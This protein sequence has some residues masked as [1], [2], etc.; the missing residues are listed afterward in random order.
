MF[1]QA[2]KHGRETF[3]VGAEN[4]SSLYFPV[5]Q[6]L[7]RGQTLAVAQ[8][9]KAGDTSVE[10]A[11]LVFDG[12]ID[13]ANVTSRPFLK[14]MRAIVPSMRHLAPQAPAV[15]LVFAT[16][17]L[18]LTGSPGAHATRRRKPGTPNAGEVILALKSL[19][20]A[21]DFSNGSDRAGGFVSPNLSV[22]AMSR[23]LGRRRRSVSA[24]RRQVRP[25]LVPGGGLPEA[26]RTLQPAGSP[27]EGPAPRRCPSV[28]VGC[29]RR[30][31]PSW[32]PRRSA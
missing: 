23:A 11:H 14:E 7:G 5:H 25:S 30:R 32:S 4:A 13:P 20:A 16:P 8:P 3:L 22:K 6:I 21:I 10:V 28:R 26:V 18:D 12:E 15:D 17:Y 29:P 27:P 19:P 9:V 31:S 24:G 2:S 1:V